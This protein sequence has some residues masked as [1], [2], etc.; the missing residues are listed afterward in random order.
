MGRRGWGSFSKYRIVVIP[1]GNLTFSLILLLPD[2]LGAHPAWPG[3]QPSEEGRLCPSSLVP[4]AALPVGNV[5]GKE[6]ELKQDL[7]LLGPSCL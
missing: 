3:S 1:A 2:I 5:E 6:R 7:Q 4:P